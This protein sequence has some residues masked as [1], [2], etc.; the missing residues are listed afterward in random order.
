MIYYHLSV[1]YINNEFVYG[2][3]EM[4]NGVSE[5]NNG[6]TVFN[7]TNGYFWSSRYL[8]FYN[9]YALEPPVICFAYDGSGFFLGGTIE[10]IATSTNA[11]WIS[12][13]SPLGVELGQDYFTY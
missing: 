12:K 4:I 1:D 2:A 7:Q 5:Y 3:Y 10:N 9:G 8:E 6:Y 13:F 11:I